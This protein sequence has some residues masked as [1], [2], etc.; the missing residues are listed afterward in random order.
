MMFIT[1]S[2]RD[3]ISKGRRRIW[4][5]ERRSGRAVQPRYSWPPPALIH[6]EVKVGGKSME[7]V[8]GA[9][10][11]GSSPPF[12]GLREGRGL[13]KIPRGDIDGL[14]EEK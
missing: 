13:L 9:G 7:D 3:Q 6:W 11:A 10:F 14:G 5:F 4:A 12:L 1:I 2:A 8:G